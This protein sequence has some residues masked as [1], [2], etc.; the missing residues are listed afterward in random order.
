MNPV[1][2]YRYDGSTSRREIVWLNFD[3][4][5]FVRIHNEN[6][7]KRFPLA[8][9]RLAPP[10]GGLARELHFADGSLCEAEPDPV[11]DR[12]LAAAGG[13]AA[14]LLHRWENSLQYALMALLL[15]LLAV[16]TGMEFGVPAL[17]RQAAFALPASTEERLGDDALAVLDRF[18]FSPSRLSAERQRQL[19][20]I[21]QRMTPADGARYR[22][23]FRASRRIG[24]N[25]LALPS[26]VVVLTDE[27]VELARRDEEI[28]AVLAHEIGHINHRHTLRQVL[29]N[30]ISGLLMAAITGD[31]L[32]TSSFAATLP[33][34]LV[35]A[36]FSRQFETEAD[37]AA[38]RYLRARGIST[39]HFAN[40]LTRLAQAHHEKEGDMSDYLSTH[41]ST[42]ER[43]QRLQNDS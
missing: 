38:V 5:G 31:I 43:I 15:T 1:R 29:Q 40:I 8:E 42:L 34:V 14:R 32:S 27:L 28:V 10:L 35:Q 16:W 39:G 21:F 33:T 4:P 2:A 11:L 6:L 17:A 23:E 12:L 36:R 20:N 3:E 41:P 25:A 18:I 37:E 22:L 24:A 30:S 19:T 26:G 13:R 9:I 7:D